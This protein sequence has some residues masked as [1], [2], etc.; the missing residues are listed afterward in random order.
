MLV[1][2]SQ[3]RS[4][5]E[6]GTAALKELETAKITGCDDMFMGRITSGALYLIDL[7]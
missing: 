7:K 6:L 2:S 3:L 4:A 5:S 1:I